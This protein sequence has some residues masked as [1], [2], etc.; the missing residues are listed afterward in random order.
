MSISEGIFNLEHNEFYFS[1]ITAIKKKVTPPTHFVCTHGT[2]PYNRFFYVVDGT[3]TFNDEHHKNLKFS[4]GDIIYLSPKT[5]YRSAWETKTD[6]DF[7]SLNFIIKDSFNKNITFSDDITFCCN[8][9]SGKLY[10]KFSELYENWEK[11]SRGTKLT[12]ISQ[13]VSIMRDIAVANEKL[14]T[15][16]L[17]RGMIKAILYLENNYLTDIDINT[18]T[19]IAHLKE[20]QFRRKFKQLKGTSV[21]KYRNMLRI[22]KAAELLKSG[23]YTVV[24]AAMIVG[25]DDP[26][27]FSRIFKAQ[28]G[29]GPKQ[30]IHYN[31][32]KA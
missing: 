9:K 18:L 6:G 13:L 4:E 3:I 14:E 20:C 2:A 31:T 22:T 7:I 25:F 1:E 27:Y 10:R 5:V 30:Y 17:N 16:G 19:D 23:E 29:V 12:T 32:N 28:I 8:D 15:K 24:E 26:N 21:I 11:Y